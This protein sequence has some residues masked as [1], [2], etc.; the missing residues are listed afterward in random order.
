MKYLFINSVAGF[1]STGKIAAEKCRELMAQGHECC[2]AYGR[3]KAN[4][5]DIPTQ[6]IGTAMDYRL[7][8]LRTRLLDD[9]GFGSKA[10][11]AR[12][13]AWAEAYAPDVVWLHN[14]HGYYIHIG[15]LFNWIKKHPD[16]Q[17]I[18]TLHDCWA[19]TGHCSHFELV[20]CEKWK[21][22]CF[23]CPQKKEYPG[24]VFLDNSRAN[25]KRKQA[26][27]T[28]V[29]NMQLI[30]PSQWLA[31]LV[32]QSFLGEYPVQVCYNTI[33]TQIFKPTPSDFR[34]RYGL[35]DKKMLLGVASVW[36]ERK[37]LNDFV[38]LAGILPDDYRIVLVGLRE[39]QSRNLPEKIIPIARTNNARELAEIYTAADCFINPTYEDNYPTVNLEAQACGTPVITYDVGGC[40]ETL[41]EISR[42]VAKGDIQAVRKLV[43]VDLQ[44]AK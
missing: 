27:F 19:L 17:V 23:A 10:A 1:G 35:Q 21:T 6:C 9:H 12:F 22:G 30:T 20:G 36:T 25:Y 32:K 28:G 44:E 13:L 26:L 34:E 8:G 16:M 41:N 18:W 42:F 14:I 38:K 3:D 33:N 15:L 40:R 11:T 5:D 39:E 29:K 7:H 24:S 4:C 31:D 37:G 2:I 43:E